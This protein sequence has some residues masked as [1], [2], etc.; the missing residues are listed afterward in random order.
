MLDWYIRDIAGFWLAFALFPLVVLLPGVALFRG[1]LPT[2]WRSATP[3][4]RIGFGLIFG[5]AVW[6]LVLVTVGR[7]GMWVM[8]AAALPAAICGAALLLRERPLPRLSFAVKAAAIVLVLSALFT[9][10][11]SLPLS[12]QD[13]PLHHMSLWD[14]QKHVAVTKMM[15]QTGIPPK[16]LLWTLEGADSGRAL[17]GYYYQFYTLPALVQT[18]SFD[19]TEVRHAFFACQA[20][21]LLAFHVLILEI[22]R[23]TTGR[24]PDPKIRHLAAGGLLFM[25]SLL[26][27]MKFDAAFLAAKEHFVNFLWG[28]SWVPQHY[29]GG[30]AAVFGLMLLA[31][32]GTPAHA[33]SWS[34]RARLGAAAA[35]SL[36]NA[37]A[38]SVP[39]GVVAATVGTIWLLDALRRRD[40][41]SALFSLI[42]G[43]TATIMAL[44]VVITM[45][46]THGQVHDGKGIVFEVRN[47]YVFEAMSHPIFA[48][49][50]TPIF[51]AVHL[52]I[53]LLGTIVCLKLFRSKLVRSPETEM[54]AV[55]AVV[56][57]LLATF[58]RSNIMNN[59]F[60]WRAIIPA[61]VVFAVLTVIAIEHLA[62]V[63][64]RLRNAFAAAFILGLVET[65]QTVVAHL[66]PNEDNIPSRNFAVRTLWDEIDRRLPPDAIVQLH[67]Y[68][69][70]FIAA[71]L[72]RTR[73]AAM[74]DAHHAV[75]YGL[76]EEEVNA[77]WRVLLKVFWDGETSVEEVRRAARRLRIDFIAVENVDPV[78]KDPNGWPHRVQPYFVSPG[79]QVYDMRDGATSAR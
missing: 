32:A 11:R 33:A 24:S 49:I 53:F 6:P 44:P 77:R 5:F 41:S 22:I 64:G 28:V 30:L 13:G 45:L 68:D 51:Y 62:K 78:W 8:L 47:P 54:L 46:A 69:K 26:S 9:L 29:T 63:P 37:L 73:W 19:L 61:Q 65:G 72:Y 67:P 1:V 18:A 57:I 71:T 75:V 20:W 43:T 40:T 34:D 76:S 7:A 23:F 3:E 17:L 60:G 16:N 36:S 2:E 4:R 12:T 59:D 58:V 14:A 39:V 42:V 25:G 21:L 56:S 27:S 15:L 31:R 48:L 50:N 70:A 74:E 10:M 55:T 66:L 38:S 79:F 35:M 52:G